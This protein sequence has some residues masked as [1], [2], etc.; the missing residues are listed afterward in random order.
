MARHRGGSRPIP[1]PPVPPSIPDIIRG[2]RGEPAAPAPVRWLWTYICHWTDEATGNEWFGG[3]HRVVTDSP[4]NY[5]RASAN[6]RRAAIADRPDCVA[7]IIRA[8]N[9]LRL[10]CSRMEEPL[11]VP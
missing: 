11:A 7:R 10:R 3:I 6:A 1:A 9:E 4:T 2:L 5:Q 8:G